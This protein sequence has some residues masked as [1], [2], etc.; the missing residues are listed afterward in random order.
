MKFAVALVALVMVVILSQG[1]AQDVE[2]VSI[3][4]TAICI[5]HVPLIIDYIMM[6]I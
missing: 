1:E 5:I 4:G 3:F 2:K 6:A